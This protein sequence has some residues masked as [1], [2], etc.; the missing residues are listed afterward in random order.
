MSPSFFARA[1]IKFTIDV[2]AFSFKLDAANNDVALAIDHH[3]RAAFVLVPAFRREVLIVRQLQHAHI[4][5][6]RC[7][8][9]AAFEPE[10]LFFNHE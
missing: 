1:R 2:G 7:V 6:L 5:R 10:D 8:A 4:G 3:D 9:G